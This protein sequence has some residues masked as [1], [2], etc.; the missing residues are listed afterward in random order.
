MTNPTLPVIGYYSLPSLVKLR[1]LKMTNR[2]ELWLTLFSRE[3]AGPR[4]SLHKV[5]QE[6][7]CDNV[8]ILQAHFW[9]N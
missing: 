2:G 5:K 8:Q 3:S 6:K 9:V 7:L 4:D 1:C